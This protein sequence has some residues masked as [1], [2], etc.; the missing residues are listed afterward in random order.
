MPVGRCV[1]RTAE[2]LCELIHRK[3][4]G[5]D[6]IYYTYT[7]EKP[8]SFNPFFTDDYKFSVEKKDSIKTLLLALWKGEDEKITKTESGELGSAVSAYIRRIQQNRDIVPSFDRVRLQGLDADKMYRVKE[9]NLMPGANSSLS[10]NG[11]V[12]SGE[13]LMNV[14]LNLFTTQQLNSRVIEVVAE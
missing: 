4:K 2:G 11:E 7:E 5:E 12:F 6:G 8:I 10:G 9:I 13:F 1:I 3:T 14:G